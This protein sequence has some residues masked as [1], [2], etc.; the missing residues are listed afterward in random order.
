[1]MT[2]DGGFTDREPTPVDGEDAGGAASRPRLSEPVSCRNH[3]DHPAESI[4]TLCG[5]YLCLLC[6]ILLDRDPDGAPSADR[7]SYCPSCAPR[8][9]TDVVL[10][11]ASVP[12]EQRAR[13]GAVRAWWATVVAV[14]TQPA[15]FMESLPLEGGLA[16]PLLFGLLMRTI[17][18][19]A[20]RSALAGV[21]LITAAAT[22]NPVV[23]VQAGV[24]LAAVLLDAG[25][26]IAQ[27][28]GVPFLLHL[29]LRIAGTEPRYEATFRLYCYAHAVDLL[30][31][32]P[33]MGPLM[34]LGLRIYLLYVGLQKAHRLPPLVTLLIAAL[35]FLLVLFLSLAGIGAAILVMMALG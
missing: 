19:V 9:R 23:A 31:L 29:G 21:V 30:D 7:L 14:F 4:C 10:L 24:Q 8:V 3:H 5:D 12:W 13:L 33:I 16:E 6:T 26:A 15:L 18:A 32:I 25:I 11:G 28:F 27:L 2:G 35:P 22:R 34:S 17:V 20:Y 1:M